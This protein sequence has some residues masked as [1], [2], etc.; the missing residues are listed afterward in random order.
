MNKKSRKKYSCKNC[1]RPY[2][3]KYKR[4][5]KRVRR[6]KLK[7]GGINYENISNNSIENLTTNQVPVF[8]NVTNGPVQPVSKFSPL[9]PSDMIIYPTPD[10]TMTPNNGQVQPANTV[11][12]T[13]QPMVPNPV[14]V[15]PMVPNPAPVQPVNNMPVKTMPVY[16]N[17][18]VRNPTGAVIAGQNGLVQQQP[19]QNESLFQK[20]KNLLGKIF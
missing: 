20:F 14:P 3:K 12:M 1:G 5:S 16:N 19:V 11:P 15:Q 2:S 18:V 13:V 17:M 9:G 6:K 10:Q 8:S 7:G 4:K